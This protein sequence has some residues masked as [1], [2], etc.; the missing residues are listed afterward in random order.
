MSIFQ[1]SRGVTTISDVNTATKQVLPDTAS[2]GHMNVSLPRGEYDALVFLGSSG[3]VNVKDSTG[4]LIVQNGIITQYGASQ[5]AGVAGTT[6]T[7]AGIQEAINVV[8]SSGTVV[9]GR[10]T[11]LISS[12]IYF[13]AQ[14]NGFFISGGG[15]GQPLGSSS[16]N[17]G[18]TILMPVLTYTYPFLVAFANPAYQQTGVVIQDIVFNDNMVNLA[19]N[20]PSAMS[21]PN[22]ISGGQSS[23]TVSSVPSGWYVGQLVKISGTGIPDQHRTIASISGTTVTIDEPLHFPSGSMSAPS[24]TITPIVGFVNLSKRQGGATNNSLL[25]IIVSESNSANQYGLVL[26]GWEDPYVAGLNCSG[27]ARVMY[28]ANTSIIS[29]LGCRLYG[30]IDIAC[31]K[32]YFN[33]ECV[34]GTTQPSTSTTPCFNILS[35]TNVNWPSFQFDNASF[36]NLNANQSEFG[37]YGTFVATSNYGVVFMVFHS[38]TFVS[39]TTA[40]Q[41]FFASPPLGGK[42]IVTLFNPHFNI[43]TNNQPI[44]S[45]NDGSDGELTIFGIDQV[46]GTGSVICP[47]SKFCGYPNIPRTIKNTYNPSIQGAGLSIIMGVDSR[48]GVTTTDASPIIVYKTTEAAR[49]IKVIFRLYATAGTTPSATYVVKWTEGGVVN[50]SSISINAVNTEAVSTLL[51]Q[52]DSLTNITSQ[53]TALS[54]TGTTVNVACVA[55]LLN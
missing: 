52:P 43:S 26:N 9:I 44:F 39:T 49:V 3:E 28:V 38:P 14:S 36:N 17:S 23:F 29:F 40:G 10:G 48:I 42:W 15:E 27:I 11:F 47:S 46:Q 8:G 13:P 53:I 54:G 25:N 4:N 12:P 18:S 21:I 31:Y 7:T 30:G 22:T 20:L 41:P 50:T 6:T 55:Q 16:I 24:G 33:S 2:V 5:G 51:V 37:T 35:D 45:V 19:N 32:A 1:P 34:F